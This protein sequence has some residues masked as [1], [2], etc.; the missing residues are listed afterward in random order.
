ML[1]QQYSCNHKTQLTPTTDQQHTRQF[2]S[3]NNLCTKHES[4]YL[5]DLVMTGRH[6]VLNNISYVPT[7]QSTEPASLNTSQRIDK[8]DRLLKI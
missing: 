1:R 2:T 3:A 8:K 4:G 6:V 5:S 7:V